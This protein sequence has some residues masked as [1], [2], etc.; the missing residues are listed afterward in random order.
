MSSNKAHAIETATMPRDPRVPS[1]M[2]SLHC[3]ATLS[4]CPVRSA[5]R[6]ARTDYV[7]SLISDALDAKA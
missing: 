3:A 5:E 2:L 6:R 7:A 4:F 1:D